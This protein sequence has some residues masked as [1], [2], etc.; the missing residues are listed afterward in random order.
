MDRFLKTFVF[1]GRLNDH[2]GREISQ[3]KV[4]IDLYDDEIFYIIEKKEPDGDYSVVEERLIPMACVLWVHHSG[5]YIDGVDKYFNVICRAYDDL[6]QESIHIQRIPIPKTGKGEDYDYERCIL[7]F[8]IVRTIWEQWKAN[9]KAQGILELGNGK[10]KFFEEQ[11]GCTIE[12]AKEEGD[13]H[14]VHGFIKDEHLEIAFW[15][16]RFQ[17]RYRD[18]WSALSIPGAIFHADY[19][20]AFENFV[21]MKSVA[22]A[23]GFKNKAELFRFAQEDKGAKNLESFEAMP[24]WGLDHLENDETPIIVIFFFISRFD[25]IFFPYDDNYRAGWVELCDMC[26]SQ[27]TYQQFLDRAEKSSKDADP[28]RLKYQYFR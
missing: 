1:R 4:S 10:R 5:V 20:D 11:Y 7:L 9:K 17:L 22:Y 26:S 28:I 3:A 8:K 19:V 6:R 16:N 24:H 12:E 21:A 27:W 25:V 2:R 18:P 15:H 13:K 14:V 23:L